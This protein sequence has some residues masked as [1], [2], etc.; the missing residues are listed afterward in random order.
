[1]T[2][3]PYAVLVS[4]VMLQQTQASRVVPAFERFLAAFPTLVGLAEASPAGVLRAWN[5]LGYNR[6]AIALYRTARQVVAEHDG[7]LPSDP[8]ALRR[9]PGVGPY[10]ASAVASIAYGV[11][12][13]AVDTNIRRVVSRAFD[14]TDAE[15]ARLADAWL[16]LSR[17]GD[18]NQALMDLG[19]DVCRPVP[20]CNACPLRRSCASASRPHRAPHSRGR[21]QPSFE[22]SFRQLRG[23]IVRELRARDSA[24]VA[25]LV[26]ATGDSPSNVSRAIAALAR[27]GLIDAEAA[28]TRGAR[29]GRVRLPR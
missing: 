16:D 28:A 24:S 8:A 25:W 27:D 7:R 29:S 5:G 26:A 23:A 14:A 12:V 22:G 1:M 15:V 11:A 20:R 10:T 3:D 2:T 9:L 19:R 13:A 18:W 6:R 21:P 17:P 4:E